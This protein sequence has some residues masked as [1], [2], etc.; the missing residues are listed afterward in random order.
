MAMEGEI[1]AIYPNASTARSID[2]IVITVDGVV[3]SDFTVDKTVPFGHFDA[4]A[5]VDLN[6]PASHEPQEVCII[7]ESEGITASCCA[8]V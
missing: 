6:V 8:F 1:D 5:S 3:S 4:P 7:A 2:S